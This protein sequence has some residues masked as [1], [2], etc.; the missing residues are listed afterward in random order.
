MKTCIK[1]GEAK[2]NIAFSH[3]RN[4]CKDCVNRAKRE[5]RRIPVTSNEIENRFLY[6]KVTTV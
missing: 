6:G 3:E 2:D 4:V 1:C 5:K